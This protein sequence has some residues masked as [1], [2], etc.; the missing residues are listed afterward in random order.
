MYNYSVLYCL[1]ALVINIILAVQTDK[2]TILS[3]TSSKL[4]YAATKADMNAKFTCAIQHKS[5][6][7]DLVSAPLTFSIHCK[8]WHFKLQCTISCASVVEQITQIN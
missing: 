7:S 6:A 3:S 4:E 2:D 1:T 5:L 8:S